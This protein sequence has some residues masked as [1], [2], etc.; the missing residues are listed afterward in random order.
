MRQGTHEPGIVFGDYDPPFNQEFATPP[1]TLDEAR[2]RHSGWRDLRQKVWNV[3]NTA[4]VANRNR[5]DRFANCGSQ[6]VAEYSP[7]ENRI[8]FVANY[9]HDRLC[10]PCAAARSAAIA[11]NLT[12]FLAH[13]PFTFL[14]L[15]LRHSRTPLKDQ[16]DRLY[17]SFA[18]LRS[19]TF[20]K[21]HVQGGV[22]VLEV[23]VSER[24][25]LWHVHLHCALHA[26]FIPQRQLSEAWHAITGDSSIVDVRRV[27]D[28]GEAARYIAKYAAKGTDSATYSLPDKLAEYISSIRGR[29]LINAFG[30]FHRIDFEK[31][32]ADPGDWQRV[33]TFQQLRQLA[34]AGN[35]TYERILAS[36]TER[37]NRQLQTA[38]STVPP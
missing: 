18:I 6:C 10:L 25:G 22:A 14:T 37:L 28:H 32:P 5:L 29:R 33:G 4:G 23:K 26:S 7:S 13:K 20:W 36:L 21:S 16:I 31:L 15:T 9:C 34:E 3:L 38:F 24:D 12:E 30:T 35:A 8:R 19:R 17:R 1:I 27:N 11:A 2:F